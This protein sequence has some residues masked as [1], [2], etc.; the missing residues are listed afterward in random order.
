MIHEMMDTLHVDVITCLV[1]IGKFNN[2]THRKIQAQEA[3]VYV[4]IFCQSDRGMKQ[5]IRYIHIYCGEIH[6]VDGMIVYISI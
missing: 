1:I 2:S 6:M 3:A 4:Y 5:I